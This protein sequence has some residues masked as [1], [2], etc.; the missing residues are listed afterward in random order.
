MKKL[1][2]YN[3]IGTMDP[4]K[5]KYEKR[6]KKTPSYCKMEMIKNNNY[7]YKNKH[8]PENKSFMSSD[9]TNSGVTLDQTK[10]NSE[11]NV[12][13]PKHLEKPN[14]NFLNSKEHINYMKTFIENINRSI[15]KNR[16]K[17]NSHSK[18]NKYYKNYFEVNKNEHKLNN[19]KP[20]FKSI[21]NNSKQEKDLLNQVNNI[22]T[23][24][25][26]MNNNNK[27]IKNNNNI[28]NNLNEK[29]T[30][31][32]LSSTL[33]SHTS[34]F[35][36]KPSNSINSSVSVSKKESNNNSKIISNIDDINLTYS[37]DNSSKRKENNYYNCKNINNNHEISRNKNNENK[38]EDFETFCE[39][40]NKK[41]FGC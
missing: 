23:L 24:K 37:D 27:I 41:L 40:I 15:S 13:I 22:K 31:S 25:N 32:Y 26:Q 6:H 9:Y 5:K 16:K 39:N 8:S 21:K 28:N 20:I 18:Q 30:N 12:K 36:S 38:L 35:N 11:K 19:L 1:T 3:I 29:N 4:I 10:L 34:I 33:I 14:F 7:I 2:L 17:R